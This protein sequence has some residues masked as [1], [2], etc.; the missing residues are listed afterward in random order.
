[1]TNENQMIDPLV[2]QLNRGWGW[3]LGFGIL[4]VI[5]G[6]IGLGMVVG[7]TLVSMIFFAVL[8]VIAGI[9]HIIDAFKYREWKG[10]IWQAL[11]AILYIA[12]GC[13]VFYDPFLASTLITALLASVLIVI[14]I[15]RIIM[16]IELRDFIGWGWLFLAGITAFI[17]GVLILAQWPISGLWVIGMFIAIELIVNGWTYIFIALTLKQTNK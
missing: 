3:L 13:I 17:L 2:G 6:F 10:I 16:A 5:L 14:G 8:L 7:L 12:A 15:A 9:S 11:I 4:S 1:M